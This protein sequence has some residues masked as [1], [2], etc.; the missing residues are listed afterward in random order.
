MSDKLHNW[1]N[2]FICAIKTK[3]N[4]RF[5]QLRAYKSIF[6]EITEFLSSWLPKNKKTPKI[7][8]PYSSENH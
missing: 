7:I 1:P 2:E 8:K 3:K 5:I 6:Q 4:A